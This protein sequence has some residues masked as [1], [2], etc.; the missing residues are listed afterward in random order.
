LT[1]PVAGR[2]VMLK[3]CRDVTRCG[4]VTREGEERMRLG[5]NLRAAAV[6]GIVGAALF[7]LAGTSSATAA[8]G[9]CSPTIVQSL[10]PGFNPL[11]ATD[12]QLEALGLPP[13]QPDP[14]WLD[15]M[16]H[17][18]QMDAGTVGCSSLPVYHPR[19]H[20][21]HHRRRHHTRRAWHGYRAAH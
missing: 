12:A 3:A 6:A 19:P 13:R 4:D 2:N 10:P 18:T 7:P 5:R 14:G 9:G 15:A 16:E 21:R 8:G 1:A 11:T 20:T 17:L